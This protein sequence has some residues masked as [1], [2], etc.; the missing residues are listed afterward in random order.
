MTS[1]AGSR[2]RASRLSSLS[3]VA[4]LAGTLIAASPL[5]AADLDL[6]PSHDPHVV[7]V[8]PDA[9]GAPDSVRVPVSPLALDPL[10]LEREPVDPPLPRSNLRVPIATPDDS[11]IVRIGSAS[12]P[13]R[14]EDG[15]V[16][17]PEARPGSAGQLPGGD[18][19]GGLV[20]VRQPLP[21]LIT[22]VARFY[23]FDAVLSR[24]VRGDVENERLPS[25]LGAFI[26]RL[27]A[28]RD[29][30]FYFR[31][32]DLNVSTRDENVS[33]VIGLGPSDPQELRAAVEA[34]GVDADRFP[35]RYI[36][37]SNSILVEGPPSFVGLV[38]VIAESLVRT[39]RA[40]PAVTVI[41]GNRIERQ[42][43]GVPPTQPAP[44]VD[45]ETEGG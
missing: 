30:V 12:R 26:A 24:Q 15:R 38:E 36:E 25:D 18:T 41:R 42:D 11:S 34:A 39:T 13:E 33:R 3:F 44:V 37:A 20:V 40:E 32:R 14:I 21:D 19:E 6:R 4:A 45:R 2:R 17:R 9:M 5:V 7:R 31:N 8:A 1:A 43:P 23:G 29:L 27:T 28:D 22:Q 35:L 10:P 16:E